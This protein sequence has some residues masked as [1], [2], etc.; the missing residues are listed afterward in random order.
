MEANAA[1]QQQ[2]FLL[3]PAELLFVFAPG[4]HHGT[5]R[6]T[7]CLSCNGASRPVLLS[8]PGET[9]AEGLGRD[10]FSE[11]A[12]VPRTR[13]LL[14]TLRDRHRPFGEIYYAES[15]DGTTK[16]ERIELLRFEC[17]FVSPVLLEISKKK[18]KMKKRYT[19]NIFQRITREDSKITVPGGFERMDSGSIRRRW[20]NRRAG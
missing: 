2:A 7:V 12:W 14:S 3:S 17:F 6:V 5:Y 9:R 11:K 19:E 16:L 4:D 1:N 18:T 20:I 10:S 13:D 15:L 8:F